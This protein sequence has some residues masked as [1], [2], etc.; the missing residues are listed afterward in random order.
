M[1]SPA[2]RERAQRAVLNLLCAFGCTMLQ[3]GLFQAD[4]M[5]ATSSCRG[6]E[7]CVTEVSQLHYG[8]QCYFQAVKERLMKLKSLMMAV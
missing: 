3:Q 2:F 1:L 8:L 6:A 4:P 5:P 7:F